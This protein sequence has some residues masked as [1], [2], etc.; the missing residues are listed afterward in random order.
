MSDSTLESLGQPANQPTTPPTTYVSIRMTI[1][2]DQWSKVIPLIESCPWYISYPHFGKT[3]ENEHF[4]VFLPGSTPADRERFRKRIKAIIPGG[5]KCYSV[6]LC[7]NGLHSAIAYGAREGTEPFTF[8]DCTAGWIS[9]APSW[10]NANLKG[11]LN[12]EG[13]SKRKREDPEGVC[14][15][16]RNFLRLCFQYAMNSESYKAWLSAGRLGT[17]KMLDIG[18]CLMKMFED[19]YYLDPV[20]ARTGMPEFYKDVYADSVRAGRITWKGTKSTWM[21]VLFRP[22][23]SRW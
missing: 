15:T 6:K 4:H 16:Q 8:G 7:E 12:P 21:S 1:K 2:H 23:N 5:N 11:N 20:F 10:I 22:V 9:G 3:G 13:G 14:V 18:H 19:G 17:P